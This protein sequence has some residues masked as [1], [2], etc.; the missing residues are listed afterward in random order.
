MQLD[1][2]RRRVAAISFL[3]NIPTDNEPT[4][5][6]LDCL[7]GTHVLRDFQR[8]K[9]QRR[10]HQ[11]MQEQRRKCQELNDHDQEGDGD[12]KPLDKD[13]LGGDEKAFNLQDL[14]EDDAIHDAIADATDDAN[15][16]AAA[17]DDIENQVDA[18]NS[19]QTSTKNKIARKLTFGKE[20]ALDGDDQDLAPSSQALPGAMV[21]PLDA[22]GGAAIS[23]LALARKASKETNL[24]HLDMSK[25]VACSASAWPSAVTGGGC[26]GSNPHPDFLTTS[27][28]TDKVIRSAPNS[29][30]VVTVTQMNSSMHLGVGGGGG[31]SVLA[32]LSSAPP[33]AVPPGFHCNPNNN[34][35]IVPMDEATASVQEQQR[36]KKRFKSVEDNIKVQEV[37]AK[38]FLASSNESLGGNLQTLTLATRLRKISGNLSE[39]SSC[40]LKEIRFFRAPHS[41]AA[42]AA[43]N[44]TSAAANNE[45]LPPLSS[46]S[47]G[48]GIKGYSQHTNERLVFVTG[49]RRTPFSVSSVVPIN[50][51][52]SGKTHRRHSLSRM[53]IRSDHGRVDGVVPSRRH[54]AN[55]FSKQLTAI[56]DGQE[57]P[58]NRNVV[59]IGDRQDDPNQD[60]SYNHLLN[61]TPMAVFVG[62]DGVLQ[63]IT[64]QQLQEEED[65]NPQQQKVGANR[66][67]HS[68][69]D[70]TVPALSTSPNTDY[71]DTIGSSGDIWNHTSSSTYSPYT[72]DGWLIAGKHRKTLSFPSYMTS[73][74]EYVK[75]HDLK[76]ELN[77]KFRERFPQLNISLTK[78][79][80]IKREMKKIALSDCNLDLL[81]LAT[82]YVYFEV[83]V[84]KA[85]VNKV[86]RKVCAGSCLILAA[87]LNDVKGPSLKGL[88]ERIENVFRIGRKDLLSSEFSVL[89]ALEFALHV[90]TWQ[91]Y[92]HYQRLLH[93]V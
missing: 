20:L 85:V 93:E 10:R 16:D 86:N 47:H 60:T 92:P 78:L 24:L 5:I 66:R 68:S 43:G 55:S 50:K 25:T 51:L 87:K 6:R 34:D 63:Q 23:A 44:V 37:S 36:I 64:Q 71:G 39:N 79:R 9:E 13:G 84:L 19:H 49:D 11:R 69:G 61:P 88:I 52:S 76:R 15:D 67:H 29:A 30:A 4:E 40:S 8:K 7:H 91:I 41:T 33:S 21:A 18:T 75:P 77:L 80:S 89:V 72:L 82:A 83:L 14:L 70:N 46:A 38:M 73:V 74:I 22:G 12:V 17:I 81:T 56:D 57:P 59:N 26:S 31:S 58:S 32:P 35:R 65:S 2:S 53:S 28:A 3:S 48:G 42:A 62:P 1:L 27:D 90:P 45:D 54:H